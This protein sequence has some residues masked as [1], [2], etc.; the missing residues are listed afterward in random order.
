MQHSVSGA[1][2]SGRQISAARADSAQHGEARHST[3]E[4]S[5]AV[6]GSVVGSVPALSTG[7]AEAGVGA[8]AGAVAG[9]PLDGVRGAEHILAAQGGPPSGAEP[10]QVAQPVVPPDALVEQFLCPITQVGIL[11]LGKSKSLP[12]SKIRSCVGPSSDVLCQGNMKLMFSI[13]GIACQ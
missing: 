7:P 4:G 3:G 1:E 8:G 10:V 9:V 11:V 6:G 13:L 5:R 12:L 2:H